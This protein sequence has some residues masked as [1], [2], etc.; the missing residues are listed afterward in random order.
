M[1]DALETTHTITKLIKKSPKRGSKLDAIKNEAK[2]ISNSEDYT[3]AIT[4]LCPTRWTVCAKSFSSIMMNY[5]YLKKLWEWAANNRSDTEMKARIRGVNV[6]IKKF[7]Y[8]YGVYLGEPRILESLL[9]ELI[10]R[11]SD[12]LS[13]T[14]QSPLLTAVQWA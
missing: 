6:Y 9:G 4:L 2:I 3:E 11:H 12:K 7:D 8:V 10:F 5:T 14:L 13:K 1:K